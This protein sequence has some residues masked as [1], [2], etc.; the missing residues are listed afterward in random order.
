[1]WFAW[2]WEWKNENGEW[3]PYSSGVQEILTMAHKQG[4][5]SGITI[6]GT[7]SQ[8]YIIDIK[9]ECQYNVKHR[10][11]KDVR[12]QLVAQTDKTKVLFYHYTTHQAREAIIQ[13]FELRA[14]G[15]GACG[16]GVYL[17]SLK[18]GTS[19]EILAKNNWRCDRWDYRKRLDIV[20]VFEFDRK[21]IGKKSGLLNH[22]KKL[23][24]DVWTYSKSIDLK[25]IPHHVYERK[26]DGYWATY[27]RQAR[28]QQQQI[29]QQ[30]AQKQKIAKS[31][32][33]P[34][35]V[36]H[37]HYGGMTVHYDHYYSSNSKPT[38][39]SS[40]NYKSLRQNKKQITSQRKSKLQAT[41]S[42]ATHKK[43]ITSQRKSRKHEENARRV[44]VT[45][46]ICHRF[47]LHPQELLVIGF[48]L[49]FT[50]LLYYRIRKQPRWKHI[51][52]SFCYCVMIAIL[53]DL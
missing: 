6:N 45:H 49:S 11:R 47:G 1:M 27:E 22:F 34:H 35:T 13:S 41:K 2:V 7:N 5:D 12:R 32:L 24:R 3:I 8:K 15:T 39:V 50:S 43:Q 42:P 25:V 30:K 36:I 44:N 33:P 19:D 29:Q 38:M 26:K 16:R 37:N 18:P 21:L 23:N 14:S 48:L 31:V 4:V 52:D 9:N 17:T 20:F 53:Q 46:W 51:F 10:T 40:A 28:I